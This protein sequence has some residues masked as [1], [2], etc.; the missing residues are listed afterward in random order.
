MNNNITFNDVA[1]GKTFADWFANQ[2]SSFTPLN[3]AVALIAALIVSVIIALVY[4]RPTGACSIPPP[5]P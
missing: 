3:V 5:S 4:K 1:N 2:L